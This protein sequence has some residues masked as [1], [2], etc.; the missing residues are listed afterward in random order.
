MSYSFPTDWYWQATDSSP[1][2]Q[3]WKSAA[4]AFVAPTTASFVTWMTD[5]SSDNIANGGLCALITD[6]ENNGA[7]LCRISLDRE[8]YWQTGDIK[9]V[10]SVSGATQ[11]NGTWTLTRIDNLTFDLQGSS[12][13]SLYTSGGVMGSGT[14]V[15]TAAEIY[16]ELNVNALR[17]A[18]NGAGGGVNTA[19]FGT[20]LTLS[21]PLQR[22]QVLT[23][24]AGGLT[25]SL[26]QQNL[27]NSTPLALP[28][29]LINASATQ[30][31]AAANVLNSPL[32]TVFPGSSLV[33]IPVAN[34]SLAGTFRS[35][36]NLSSTLA[37]SLLLGGTGSNLSGTGGTS[38]VLKQATVGGAVTVGQ[39]AF[40]DLSD[41]VAT[42]VWTPQLKF[43]GANSG[44]TGTFAGSYVKIGKLVVASYRI[45]LTAKGA[46]TGRAT[47]TGLPVSPTSSGI[48]ELLFVT[49][50][51]SLT[52]PVSG[53]AFTDSVI[54]L[55][56]QGAAASTD[57]SEANFTN[58]SDFY[59]T[60]VYIA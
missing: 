56:F 7:G 1:S 39:L 40:S 28:L 3:V 21:N 41:Y 32:Y 24:T 26:P 2:T 44:M 34:A 59:G 11:A 60:A 20:N 27:A 54:Y 48:H 38:Q 10:A 25:V 22:V 50:G 58:T 30:S 42:T 9:T 4:G 17:L 6:V 53:F 36:G 35:A 55:E 46:S 8:A 5:L 18:N 47:I 45:T 29:F 12:T 33:L 23:P 16:A 49:G 15:A 13:P 43:G 14:L 31:F 37:L 52:T 19:S 57:L 51:A